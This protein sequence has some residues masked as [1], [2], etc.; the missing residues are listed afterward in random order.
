M[1]L[2][3]Q[4]VVVALA[5]AV[6]P[7]RPWSYQAIEAGTGL[8]Q[9]A[10]FRALQRL[11]SARLVVPNGWRVFDER[12]LSFLEHGV[13]YA[14]AVAPGGLAR[15]VPTAWAAPPLDAHISAERGVVWPHPKGTLRAESLEPLAPSAVDAAL[16]DPA[17]YRV[18]ALVDGLRIGRPREQQLAAKASEGGVR[19]CADRP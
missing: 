1:S 4:D 8:S 18:L 3:S 7:E 11:R 15:G 12:L 9:S 6:H 14:F 5:L 19:A 2:K 17:L 16:E 13:P 10:S